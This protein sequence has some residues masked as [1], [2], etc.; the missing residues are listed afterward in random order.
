V[1][2]V[3]ESVLAPTGASSGAALSKADLSSTLKTPTKQHLLVYKQAE[4]ELLAAVESE[5]RENAV[6]SGLLRESQ[7]EVALCEEQVRPS[8]LSLILSFFSL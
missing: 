4:Q 5:R 3:L 1:L 6:L 8:L 7:R 2:S